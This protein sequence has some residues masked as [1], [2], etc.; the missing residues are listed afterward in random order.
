[1]SKQQSYRE[2]QKRYSILIKNKFVGIWSQKTPFYITMFITIL[3]F[4]TLEIMKA[5]IVVVRIC[6]REKYEIIII[7]YFLF[8]PSLVSNIS[9]NFWFL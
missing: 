2:G 1:M 7:I 4:S 8:I 3:I 6:E 5:M 9:G